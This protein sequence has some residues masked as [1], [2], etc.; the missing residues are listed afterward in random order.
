MPDHVHL[1]VSLHQDVAVSSLIRNVKSRSTG[2]VRC[3]RGFRDAFGWQRGYA[4]FSVSASQV[5]AVRRYIENQEEHHRTE[6][7]KAEFREL[8]RKH[9][10]EFTEEELWD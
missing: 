8:L 7:F 5:P 10:I 3:W 9:G 2:A 1:L 6:P 4:G